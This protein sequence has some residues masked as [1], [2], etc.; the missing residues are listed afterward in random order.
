MML[1]RKKKKVKER[2]PI[3]TTKFALGVE[4]GGLLRKSCISRLS[5]E[6]CLGSHAFL[7]LE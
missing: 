4:C 5:V 1:R 3:E 2:F 7:G 6:V